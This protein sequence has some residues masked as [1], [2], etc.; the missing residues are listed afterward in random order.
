[1]A[2]FMRTKLIEELQKKVDAAV[3]VDEE[4]QEEYVKALHL[5]QDTVVSK[6][7]KAVKEFNPAKP[8]GPIT[9]LGYNSSFAPPSHPSQNSMNAYKNAIKELELMAEDM[10]Q[11]APSSEFLKLVH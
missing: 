2:K 10:I 4:R 9:A 5:W 6:F 8:T 3:K 1:M 11:L 7:E